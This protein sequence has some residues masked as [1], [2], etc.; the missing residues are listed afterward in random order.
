MSEFNGQQASGSEATNRR[1]L[2]QAVATRIGRKRDESLPPRLLRVLVIDDDRDTAEGVSRLVKHWGHQV[3]Q[4]DSAQAG[5]EVAVA[6]RPDLL[7][8]D[9]SMPIMDGCEMAC[10]IRLDSRLDGCF[11]VAVTGYADDEQ[12]T[13]CFEAGVDLFLVKPVDPVV[14]ESL[15]D[16]EGNYVKRPPQ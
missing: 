11:I 13:R 16:L 4:V 10:L 9:I 15:L 12:R 1:D 14:L 2:R 5:L 3:H 8:L 7:L 6:Y